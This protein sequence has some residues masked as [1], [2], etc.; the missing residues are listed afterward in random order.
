MNAHKVEIM[1]RNRRV[2]EQRVKDLIK[3]KNDCQR[4]SSMNI[5][6]VTRSTTTRTTTRTR[7][8]SHH[9]YD[10]HYGQ[11]MN[12]MND[13]KD[14]LKVEEMKEEKEAERQRLQNMKY[15]EQKQQE[16]QTLERE[17]LEREIQRICESSEELRELERN[18]QTAYVNKERAAQHQESLLIKRLENAREQMIEDEMEK[19]RQ[20]LINIELQK[21]A[22]R[23]EQLVA[24]KMVL[25][26]QMKE[27]EVRG[28]MNEVTIALFVT[29]NY[30]Y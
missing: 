23:R 6:D 11:S 25:Q 30:E 8:R 5:K 13:E 17:K 16:T 28:N 22:E 4:L 26:G 29:L 27:N 15:E 3:Y 9:D 18:I 1:T 12:G 14:K 21:E 20:E 7:T 19:N 24:Q 10:P 2:D